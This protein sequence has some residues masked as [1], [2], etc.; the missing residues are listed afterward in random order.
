MKFTKRLFSLI[1]TMFVCL[2]IVANT[3]HLK[4]EETNQTGNN[5][6][7]AGE[8]MSAESSSPQ[9]EPSNLAKP[10]PQ[11]DPSN[12]S[13]P[14]PQADPSNLSEAAPQTAPSNL[15]EPELQTGTVD[16][17]R[18]PSTFRKSCPTRKSCAFR[19]SCSNG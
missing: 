12:L 3:P 5:I 13:E 8:V 18:K 2:T 19:K 16:S 15:N 10:A 9:E 17:S 4:G 14:A 11:A 6:N 1:L 7:N